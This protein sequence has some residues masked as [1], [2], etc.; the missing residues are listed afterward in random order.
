MQDRNQPNRAGRGRGRALAQKTKTRSPVREVTRVN[1]CQD[2]QLKED[3]G[4]CERASASEG[5]ELFFADQRVPARQA[6]RA[7]QAGSASL[8]AARRL[9]GPQAFISFL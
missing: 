2:T 1:T 3:A 4:G 8:E 9:R 7:P 5:L 6:K